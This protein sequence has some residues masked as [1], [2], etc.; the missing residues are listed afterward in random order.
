MKKVIEEITLHKDEYY[1]FGECGKEIVSISI[2]P[3]LPRPVYP[4]VYLSLRKSMGQDCLNLCINEE[5]SLKGLAG[6]GVYAGTVTPTEEALLR[7]EVEYRVEGGR[8][9]PLE[10]CDAA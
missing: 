2:S 3:Y 8:N 5:F 10:S 9:E 4:P 6:T 1:E 7:I